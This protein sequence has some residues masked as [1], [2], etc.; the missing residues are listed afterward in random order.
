M[1][2]TKHQTDLTEVLNAMKYTRNEIERKLEDYPAM[3]REIAVLQFELEHPAMV[4][5]DEMREA[6]TFARGDCV[7]GAK[8][9][10]S[11]KTMYIALNYRQ[12]AE[13]A[14]QERV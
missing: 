11:D 13:R 5:E 8:G 4:S 9:H 12:A 1:G 10:I 2:F 7:G 3:E 6:M 14:N